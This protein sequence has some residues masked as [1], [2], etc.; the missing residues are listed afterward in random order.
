ML[1]LLQKPK[2]EDLRVF[3]KKVDN[4]MTKSSYALFRKSKWDKKKGRFYIKEIKK[5]CYYIGCNSTYTIDPCSGVFKLFK[6]K[7]VILDSATEMCG[8]TFIIKFIKELYSKS[9][10]LVNDNGVQRYVIKCDKNEL[11]SVFRSTV[12]LYKA[13]FNAEPEQKFADLLEYYAKGFNEKEKYTKIKVIDGLQKILFD[14]LDDFTFG[15]F[16]KIDL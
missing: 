10:K 7:K 3:L 13:F 4:K 1:S 5:G 12:H 6:D 2:N 16:K 8:K 11:V 9:I 14:P 15:I